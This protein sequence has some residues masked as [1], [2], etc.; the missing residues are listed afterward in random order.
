MADNDSAYGPAPPRERIRS[1]EQ[2]RADVPPAP[3][4]AG[5]DS[6]ACQQCGATVPSST[7][8]HEEGQDYMRHFCGPPC[9]DAWQKTVK[10]DIP[11]PAPEGGKA[12]GGDRGSD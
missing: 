7:A 3:D 2:D 1:P 11:A 6:S 9:F 4:A 5:H 12:A 8:V 10:Q